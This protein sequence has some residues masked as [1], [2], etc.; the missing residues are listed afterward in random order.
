MVY[1]DDFD[2]KLVKVARRESRIVVDTYYIGYVLKFE[3]DINSINPLN[4]IVKSLLGR[5]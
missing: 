5:I 4:L 3:Y 2:I 1:L